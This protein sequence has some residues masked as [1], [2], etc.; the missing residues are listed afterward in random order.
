[1]KSKQIM[2][3]SYYDLEPQEKRFYTINCERLELNKCDKCE[4][5]ESTYDLYWDCDYNLKGWTCLCK[6]CYEK[7]RGTHEKI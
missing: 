6:E 7:E 1:M 4:E 2:Y 5:I 3:R